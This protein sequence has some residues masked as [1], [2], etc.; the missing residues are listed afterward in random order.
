M[1]TTVTAVT[2]DI[3]NNPWTLTIKA[4][5]GTTPDKITLTQDGILIEYPSYSIEEPLIL[6]KFTFKILGTPSTT[7][8]QFGGI[9]NQTHSFTLTGVSNGNN[10]QWKGYLTP[11]LYSIANTG[12][13]EVVELNGISE[14]EALK[15]EDFDLETENMRPIQSCIG[16]LLSGVGTPVYDLAF[17]PTNS[18]NHYVAYR[19]WSDEE[20][21]PMTKFDVIK[22]ICQFYSLILTQDFFLST[23][24]IRSYAKLWGLTSSPLN[25][26]TI[27]HKGINE[28]YSNT[29]TYMSASVVNSI[30]KPE[31]VVID[32]KND[33]ALENPYTYQLR[34]WIWKSDFHV[35]KIFRSWVTYEVRL[36]VLNQEDMGGD[37]EFPH[38]TGTGDP[39]TEWWNPDKVIQSGTQK[40]PY[41]GMYDV[42]YRK[43]E[44]S[45]A[46]P[47]NFTDSKM[48]KFF[49]IKT[50][51]R[52][53]G[54]NDVE[55]VPQA[56]TYA[57]YKHEISV[58]SDDYLLFSG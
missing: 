43:W 9:E 31:D 30:L 37:W 51:N 13:D 19:N 36:H 23:I 33:T 54:S 52:M 7:I 28:M 41:A 12:F 15:Y 24:T 40:I 35:N 22:H 42:S 2:Y 26:A 25:Y 57:K 4:I 48:N 55:L 21:K 5:N 49:L 58:K 3:N 46:L 32:L 29:D 10:C 11:D 47:G 1:A 6:P 34:T 27:K 38:Y 17:Q 16:T 8:E 39:I 20:E 56:Y 45:S 18:L 44:S 14:I 53:Q 50:F